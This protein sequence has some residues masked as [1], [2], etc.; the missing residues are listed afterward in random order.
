MTPSSEVVAYR[1]SSV[2]T[3]PQL[4]CWQ[5][6]GSLP[7]FLP[8]P[9]LAIAVGLMIYSLSWQILLLARCRK[10]QFPI[11]PKR[12]SRAEG[13]HRVQNRKALLALSTCRFRAI[14][15]PMIGIEFESTMPA[16]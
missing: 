14:G 5:D 16:S 7:N 12:R 13:S 6:D 1:L 15:R 10:H 11:Q 8:K 2:M 4:Q 3:V 9:F